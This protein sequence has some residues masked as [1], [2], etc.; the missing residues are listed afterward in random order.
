MDPERDLNFLALFGE[1]VV[2]SRGRGRDSNRKVTG[3]LVVSLLSVNCIFWSHP[4]CLGW[5]V[6]TFAHSG[7]A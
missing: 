5:K 1:G 3:M 6:T 7:I 2:L 4:G